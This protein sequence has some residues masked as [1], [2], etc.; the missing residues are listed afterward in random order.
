MRNFKL[1]FGIITLSISQLSFASIPTDEAL[2]KNH[3]NGAPNNVTILKWV[4]S[5]ESSGQKA[6]DGNE[7]VRFVL[8]KQDKIGLLQTVF[9]NAQMLPSQIKSEKWIPDIATQIK[10]E[11]NSDRAFFHALCSMLVQNRNEELALVLEKMGQSI[12]PRSALVNE[13]KMKL[14]R[15]YRSYLA[16]NRGRGEEGSPLNP[17]DK[18]EKVAV[19]NLF[20]SP[21]VK[22]S[23]NVQL[24]KVRDE[25]FWKVDY[26]P[27]AL[28]FENESR[29]FRSLKYDLPEG[30]VEI[31]AK[32]FLS[33]NST[34]L[35]PK[36]LKVKDLKNEWTTFTLMQFEGKKLLDKAIEK[37][38]LANSE[39]GAATTKQ[40]ESDLSVLF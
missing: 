22:K 20:K 29:Y 36:T 38:I 17:S 27:V 37:S 30:Q 12:T 21:S 34:N 26:K 33:F 14:L 2:L 8:V 39:Q 35:F 4:A 23:K 28:W 6:D 32:Q 3:I 24:E 25:F 16:T 15:S 11:K 9:S 31:E 5:K 40:V 10:K 7:Y 19:L 18:N 13:E 1:F